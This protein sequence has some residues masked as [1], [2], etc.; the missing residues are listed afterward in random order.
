MSLNLV[1]KGNLI[2][3][4]NHTCYKMCNKRIYLW[5]RAAGSR[6]RMQRGLLITD[7]L[8][9]S[10]GLWASQVKSDSGGIGLAIR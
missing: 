6:A 9:V 7:Q 4:E 8:A 5:H 1:R 2:R 10:S 3:N